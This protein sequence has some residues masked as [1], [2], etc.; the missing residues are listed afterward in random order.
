MTLCPAHWARRTSPACQS[1][2]PGFGRLFCFGQRAEFGGDGCGLC[3]VVPGD[4]P[5]KP[6]DA[7]SIRPTTVMSWACVGFGGR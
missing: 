7:V 3:H 2:R 1:V 5:S 4:S 6:E